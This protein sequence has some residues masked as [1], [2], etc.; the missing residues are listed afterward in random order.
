MTKAESLNSMEEKDKDIKVE[1]ARK[2]NKNRKRTVQ[3]STKMN[4]CRSKR[5]RNYPIVQMIYKTIQNL[6]R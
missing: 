1:N 4:K 2:K 3:K 5:R 6:Q